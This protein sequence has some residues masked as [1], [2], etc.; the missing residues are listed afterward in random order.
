[1]TRV[2][3]KKLDTEG[4]LVSSPMVAQNDMVTVTLSLNTLTY[5][6]VGTNSK[7]LKTGSG[8]NIQNLKKEAKEALKELNVVFQDEIRSRLKGESNV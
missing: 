3:Y 1:M 6:I 7:V 5:A 4:L 8:K 2:R